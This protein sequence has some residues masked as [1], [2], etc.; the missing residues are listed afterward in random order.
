MLSL[1]FGVAHPCCLPLGFGVG[2]GS[3]FGVSHRDLRSVE[4]S[5]N[6]LLHPGG[7]GDD[8]VVLGRLELLPKTSVRRFRRGGCRLGA[9]EFGTVHWVVWDS[10]R[11][12]E[13]MPSVRRGCPAFGW[14]KRQSDQW[15]DSGFGLGGLFVGVQAFISSSGSLFSMLYYSIFK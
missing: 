3:G 12:S 2:Y 5:S 7:S 4:I 14:H 11:P 13:S 9:G 8:G 6:F 10:I 15:P 1:G